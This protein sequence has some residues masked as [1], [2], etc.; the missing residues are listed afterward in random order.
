MSIE[1]VKKCKISKIYL[2]IAY[3]FPNLHLTQNPPISIKPFEYILIPLT[4]S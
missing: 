1:V 3:D 2:S 4:K